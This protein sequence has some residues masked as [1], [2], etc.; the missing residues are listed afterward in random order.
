MKIGIIVEGQEGLSW[1]VWRRMTAQIEALGFDSLWRSDHLLSTGDERR[2]AHDTWLALTVAAAETKR[3]QIGSLVSP[4]TFRNPAHLAKLVA[5]VDTLSDGRLVLGLGAGW[6][7]REHRA[8]GL[9]FP[10]LKERLERLEE[11]IEIIFRMQSDGPVSYNGRYYHIDQIDSH[12]KPIQKPRVPLLIGGKG[13]TRFLRIVARYAN[14]W[15][16]TTNSLA[17]YHERREQL[18]VVCRDMGRNPADI[19]HSVS[20]GLLVGRDQREIE[21]RCQALQK[22]SPA[23]ASVNTPEIPEAMRAVGWACGTPEAI[24]RQLQDLSMAGINRVMFQHHD[25]DDDDVLTLIAQEILPAVAPC[26][27]ADAE[28]SGG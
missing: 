18:A 21:H 25:F 13:K 7:D 14:E 1:A 27:R 6:N 4:I 22:L 12:P 17:F 23:L 5:S 20:M 10:P 3:L 16:M 9:P 26:N 2:E 15:N 19:Q 28:R 8:Y 11:G 24:V